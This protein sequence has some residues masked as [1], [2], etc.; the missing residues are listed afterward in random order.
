MHV[1]V[2][3]YVKYRKHVTCA[4]FWLGCTE[5]TIRV[6]FG[7]MPCEAYSCWLWI[8]MYVCWDCP[9]CMEWCLIW[10]V[11][12]GSGLVYIVFTLWALCFVSMCLPWGEV[13]VWYCYECA[14]FI[15]FVFVIAFSW[16][17]LRWPSLSFRLAMDCQLLE[18]LLIWCGC[19]S[20][21]SSTYHLVSYTC[22]LLLVSRRAV[23]SREAK[24]K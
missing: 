17:V 3:M 6:F 16:L 13:V 11:C 9:L 23:V 10:A 14:L 2:Y 5:C 18:S 1:T 12:I 15:A 24:K 4:R 20:L 21:T 22:V 19:S 7:L 8:I